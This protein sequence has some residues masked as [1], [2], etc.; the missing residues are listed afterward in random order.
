MKALPP[1][2][3]EDIFKLLPKHLQKQTSGSR[4]PSDTEVRRRVADISEPAEPDRPK[5]RSRCLRLRL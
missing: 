3:Q 2:T 5:R 1:K 4:R